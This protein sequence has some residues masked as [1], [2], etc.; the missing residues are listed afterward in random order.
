MLWLTIAS[1]ILAGGALYYAQRQTAIA[2]ALKAHQDEQEREVHNW[3]LKHEA[4]AVQL[5]RVGPHMMVPVGN[6]NALASAYATV[7]ND[8]QFRQKVETY[9]VEYAEN[10]TRF[11]PR[12]PT[13][14][15]LR[16]PALRETVTKATELLDRCRQ[17][18]PGFYR[19]FQ[20]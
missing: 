11:V 15:E 10:R 20:E 13:A 3:Q 7:F 2:N 12:R 14:L 9:I 19:Y 1:V 16:S 18:N 6:A 8:P 5:A 17:D 4:V